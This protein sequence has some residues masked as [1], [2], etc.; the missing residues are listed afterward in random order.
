VGLWFI[1]VGCFAG[2]QAEFSQPFGFILPVN[3]SAEESEHF[4][5]VVTVEADIPSG[6]L[7]ILPYPTFDILWLAENVGGVPGLRDLDDDSLFEILSRE[8]G[9]CARIFSRGGR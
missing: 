3:D 7:G 5:D 4:R 8:F 1:K 9:I 2:A 6:G